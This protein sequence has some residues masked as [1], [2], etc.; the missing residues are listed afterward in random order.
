MIGST[1]RSEDDLTVAYK[2]IIKQNK[3]IERAIKAGSTET[4]INELR[5][6][7]QFYSATLMDNKING[8]GTQKHKS[9]QPLK[10][11]RERLKGKEGRLRGNLM[12]KRC[13]FTA[14]SVITCDPN[15]MLDQLGVPKEI[16]M[17]MTVP[18][19]VTAQNMDYMRRLVIQGA[20][21]HPGAKFIKRLDGKFIDLSMLPNRTDQ[22]LEIGY[23][24][25]RHL[26][27]GDYVI[28]N[29]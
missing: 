6:V 10:A 1:S 9:G 15:L 21:N 22:H 13:D 3:E 5:Y 4:S 16:A 27:D 8:C 24:V 19:V 25:E 20:T 29:R 14:R 11:I 18:E 17:N 2:Q 28:F 7:L 23:T 12:G 26:Q